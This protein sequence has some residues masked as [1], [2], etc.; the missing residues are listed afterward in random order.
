VRFDDRLQTIK[1]MSV[2]GTSAAA[3]RW[4]QLI[5]LL[6]QSDA[7]L[8][9]LDKADLDE[10]ESLGADV[11]ED[12]KLSA[13][14]A[15][16]ARTR[17]PVVV[18]LFARERARVAAPVLLGADLSENEWITLIPQMSSEARGLLRQ[19]RALP[20]GAWQLLQRYGP[21]D[22]ALPDQTLADHSVVDQSV[23]EQAPPDSD[24][25]ELQATQVVADH[26]SEAEDG[27]IS[28][29]SD[30]VA[31]IDRWQRQRD[32][33]KAGAVSLPGQKTV[34]SDVQ[35]QP[36]A[37]PEFRFETDNSAIVQW[38]DGVPAAAL[39]GLDLSDLA[40]PTG[41][42]ADGQITG[43]VAK[44]T[45]ITNGRLSLD[46][47]GAAGGMWR[48]SA[49]PVFGS[50]DGRFQGYRGLAKRMGEP[51]TPQQ[52]AKSTPAMPDDFGRQ[53][54]HELRAPL[55]A[56]SGFA[57]MISGQVL[58]PVASPY[59]TQAQGIV[60]DAARLLGMVDALDLASRVPPQ[61]QP[62]E[63]TDCNTCLT[64]L[65][66]HARQHAAALSIDAEVNLSRLAVDKPTMIR[67]LT[68][69]RDTITA[70]LAPDEAVA[71]DVGADGAMIG[72]AFQRPQALVKMS[73]DEL[74]SM[75]DQ[76]E[77]SDNAAAMMALSF[78]LRMLSITA[79]RFGGRFVIA[80]R[81]TL[82]VPAVTASG[83]AMKESL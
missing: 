65:A 24:V 37:I 39:I 43:P 35:M 59:R 36:Q 77:Q 17:S 7:G 66:D 28:R 18:A 79:E 31:R 44:R 76:P 80:E 16:G 58:G 82:L 22:F 74:L 50:A 49:M 10:I 68:R 81:F 48:V 25:L 45:A 14:M 78:T 2:S 38:V 62:E 32:E 75:D 3:A 26:Q 5:D 23:P 55:T 19:R 83:E 42:G 9:M 63:G 47:H 73:S 53:V 12:R 41:Y 56:I 57:E 29:I 27:G 69:L 33:A 20:D 61:G 67:C 13:A 46:P 4:S 51:V 21:A 30:L 60:S 34:A 64:A 40:P 6:A 71:L 1:A 11:P 52:A 72:F 8:A 54:A 15:V 70:W